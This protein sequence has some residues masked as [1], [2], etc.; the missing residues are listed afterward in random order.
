MMPYVMRK[1]H[2]C[3]GREGT[4]VLGSRGTS[5]WII[6]FFKQEMMIVWTGTGNKSNIIRR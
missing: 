4:G 6:V 3:K 5:Y 1:R 2:V